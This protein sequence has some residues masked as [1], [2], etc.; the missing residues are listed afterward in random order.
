MQR[1]SI[2]FSCRHQA[3]QFR[4]AHSS[5]ACPFGHMTSFNVTGVCDLQGD[6]A[7]LR[8][9]VPQTEPQVRVS[10]PTPEDILAK[11]HEGTIKV[12]PTR[13]PVTRKLVT[14]AL[15]NI[16]RLLRFQSGPSGGWSPQAQ[17]R[18]EALLAK[19]EKNGQKNPLPIKDK[20]RSSQSSSTSHA[21]KKD[22]LPIKD[23]PQSSQS[24]SSSS[25]S[26]SES[27]D[28]DQA[29]AAQASPMEAVHILAT[30]L[31]AAK[32]TLKEK[33]V[34]IAAV[35]QDFE[36]V[37]SALHH[38]QAELDD[39]MEALKQKDALIASLQRDLDYF[40]FDEMSDDDAMAS[41]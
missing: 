33:D 9:Q 40:R 14:N 37:C 19:P 18:L 12:H 2:G 17:T 10:R 13:L 28:T 36:S 23:K 38:C 25:T 30:S 20:P 15:N 22:L 24:T 3:F 32:N 16:Q 29:V 21:R 26:S 39:A 8:L 35:T 27:S 11:I 4:S 5:A 41:D 34:K 1:S 31:E 7:I 6:G